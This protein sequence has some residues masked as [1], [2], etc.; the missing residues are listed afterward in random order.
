MNISETKTQHMTPRNMYF[1]D[2]SQILLEQRI[3]MAHIEPNQQ[4]TRVFEQRLLE[5]R[6]PIAQVGPT[7]QKH[8]CF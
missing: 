6:A 4:N 5:H 1:R 3:P 2:S 8:A 7:Q